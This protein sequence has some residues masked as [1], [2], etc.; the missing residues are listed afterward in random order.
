MGGR[1]HA[2]ATLSSSA[3]LV[4]AAGLVWPSWRAASQGRLVR[5]RRNADGC[6]GAC[7]RQAAETWSQTATQ[8]PSS[9]AVHEGT[10]TTALVRQ[11]GK[12]KDFTLESDSILC[13]ALI[14]KLGGLE[15]Q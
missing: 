9:G 12:I 14:L 4:P 3:D 6:D 8:S 5:S 10:A 7:Y 15:G 13:F 1:K 11:V 2:M